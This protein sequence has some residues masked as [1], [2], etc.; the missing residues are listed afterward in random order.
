[1]IEGLTE[2]EFQ[3]LNEKLIQPLK[4]HGAQVFL[5]GSRANGKFQKFSDIDLLYVESDQ[6]SLPG[7]F[8]YSLLAEIEESNFPYKIDLVNE[9]ELATS[10]RANVELQKIAL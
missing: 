3:F 1:M 4:K 8:I 10:Y 2:G 7:Y 6:Q 5:F 9:Q